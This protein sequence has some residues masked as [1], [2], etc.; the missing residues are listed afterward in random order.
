MT[1]RRIS[2]LPRYKRT[3]AL[4]AET[5]ELLAAEVAERR[6]D[7]DLEGRED[8]LSMLVAAR[9]E[10]GSSMDDT[11]IRD[12]LMTLLLAG[13]ETTAT[14]LAW[15]FELLY[16][17][18]EALERATADA[19]EGDGAYLDA[20]ATESMRLRPVVPF[21]GRMLLQPAELGGYELPAKTTILAS[22]WL[23]HTREA[24]F[25]DPYAFRPER[26]LDGGAE[27]YSWIPF[28][29]GTRRCLG[30]AFAQMEMRV[31]LQTLLRRAV[32]A[33]ASDRPEKVVRRNVTLAPSRGTPSVLRERLAA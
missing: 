26:F 3:R 13:H 27:T 23:A 32:L 11:E 1:L 19:R 31:A 22:I 16:R 33:P 25:P 20:V 28:G 21:T 29:G 4:I 14:A 9:F 30:A 8:I 18:P 24:T 7:P 12:Q 6:A 15:T 5:D 17:S 10:D 2:W